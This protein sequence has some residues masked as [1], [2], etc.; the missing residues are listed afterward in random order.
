MKA[1]I[2]LRAFLLAT[3]APLCLTEIAR[4][5][6][7]ARVENLTGG[8][9]CGSGNVPRYLTPGSFSAA[10]ERAQAEKRAL[11]IKGVAFGMDRIGAT[12]PTKGHW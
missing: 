11:L 1:P 7:D 4:G 6:E 9:Q 2:P 5:Q 3:L 10:L 8:P 12:L